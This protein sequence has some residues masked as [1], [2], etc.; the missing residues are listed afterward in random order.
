MTS[1]RRAMR[2]APRHAHDTWALAYPPTH[3][4]G[5]LVWCQAVA[6]LNPLV[7]VNGLSPEEVMNALD[8][9]QVTHISGTPTFYRLLFGSGRVAQS[10]RSVTIGGEASSHDLHDKLGRI[11]PGARI[12]N[13]Y[14]STEAGTIL[15]ANGEV[16]AI[17]AALSDRVRIEAGR[18]HIHSSLL[19]KVEGRNFGTGEWF[20]TGDEVHVVEADP[21]RFRFAGRRRETVNVGGEKVYPHEVEEVMRGHP[22]VADALVF[23][24]P[25]SVTGALLHAD[26]VLG[27]GILS[28]VEL[29]AYAAQRLQPYKVPRMIKFVKQLSSTH[30][31]K[32]LRR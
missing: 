10:V 1:L 2:I 22:V 14:A 5:V 13:V 29:R 24:Q 27:Q 7:D 6:N 16:F 32:A 23:G 31:G 4:G 9:H 11:F 25:N 28:E 15:E 8:R 18:I 12:H 26:V 17:P 3:I 30:S 19:A 21:L 20:D